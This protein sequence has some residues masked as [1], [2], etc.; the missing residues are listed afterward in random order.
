MIRFLIVLSLVAA[1]SK[2]AD[3]K[4]APAPTQNTTATAATP[5][6]TALSNAELVRFCSLCYFKM[7]DCFKDAEFWQTFSTM[8][9]ANTNIAVDDVEREHWIGIMKED[10]LK[11]YNEHGFEE[12]CKASLEHNKA[13]SDR[14]VKAVT[15]AA[16]RSCSAFA[17]AFGYMI[18]NEGAL[19][20]P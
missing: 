12:N 16:G 7:M 20:Q 11:L 4:P 18:F 17:S 8:Y 14:S 19:H 15:D 3:P 6:P 13:P 9:F 10:L 5:A 1:C 2:S